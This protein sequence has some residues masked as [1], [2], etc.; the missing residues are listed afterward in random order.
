MP[1]ATAAPEPG[2]GIAPE[3]IGANARAPLVDPY[4]A[5]M[6][7]GNTPWPWRYALVPA[8]AAAMLTGILLLA[9]HWLLVDELARRSLL[10]AQHRA[11]TLAQQLDAQMRSAQR[12]LRLMAR[13][14]R[15]TGAPADVAA[16]LELLR[17][18]SVNF[19]WIG[20][21]TPD[22]IVRAATRGW[23]EGQSIASRPVFRQSLKGSFVGDAHPAVALADLMSRQGQAAEE[24]LDVGEPVFDAQGR[25]VAVLAAHLGVGWVDRL[26]RAERGEAEGHPVPG[27]S[28]HVLSGVAGRSVVAGAGAP[29]GVPSLLAQPALVRDLAGT[30]YF[31]ASADLGSAA[32]PALLP[33]R[34]LVLQERSAAL[35]PAW[36]V[37]RSMAVLGIGAALAIGLAGVW[38]SRRLLQPWGPM[39]R[40]VL[41]RAQRGGGDAR[42]LAEDVEAIVRDIEQRHAGHALSGPEALLLRLARDASD[43]RRVVDHLPICVALIDAGFRVEYLNPAYT[44]LLGWTTERVRGRVAAEFL[45][46]AV[47]RAEFVRQ[48]DLLDD[49]PGQFGARFFA[50][51]P[52]G[53]RVAVQWQFVPML[54]A[55]G[56]MAGAIALAHDIR[57][58]LAARARADALAGRLRALADAA[59]DTLLSTLDGEG[60]VL[61]WNR[62]AEHL[63]GLAAAAAL[64]RP[65]GDV[66][67][68]GTSIGA[69][70][71]EA[72]RSGRCALAWSCTLVGGRERRFEGSVYP[73]GLAPGTARFGLILHDLTEQHAVH[74]ALERSEA[75]MR[76]AMDAARIGTWEI[77]LCDPHRPVTWSAGYA[78]T[79]GMHLDEL[80]RTSEALYALVHPEDH[81][82]VRHAFVV[83]VRDA[84]ALRTEFRI[85]VEPGWRWHEI[86]GRAIRGADGQALRVGGIGMDTTERRLAEAELRAGRERL[87]RILHTM[88]EGLVTFD[89]EGRYTMVNRATERIVGEPAA[90]IIG[91]RYDD[92]SWRRVAPD[93]GEQAP[94]NHAFARLRRGEP[95]I[96]GE[97]VGV[98][99]AGRPPRITS[100]NAQPVFGAAGRFEGAV[101]TYVDIT[102]RW[103][104]ERALADSQARLSAVVG[105][106]SDAILS[107]D[108][109][110]RISL[111]NPAAERI[112]GQPAAD[113][114]GQ[115]LDRLLPVARRAG[116]RT[117]LHGFAASGVSRR[118]MGAGRVQGVHASGRTLELEASISQARVNGQVVLTAILRDVTDRVAQEQALDATRHE[119]AQLNRRLLEQEKE[120]TRHV[121]QALH[122]ELGQTLSALR[123]NWDALD[124][125]PEAVRGQH[126]DRLGAL[127][128]TANRQ[129]RHVLGELRPPLLDEMGL[130]AALDNELQQ[131]RPLL[132]G[133]QLQLTVPPRLHAHR[134]PPDVEY[135]AFMI[136]REALVN[137]LQHASASRVS[138]T[139][140]G[141]AG[142]LRLCV[143]DDGVGI[144]AEARAGRA[145]HLGLVG[146]RERAFAIGAQL[147]VDSSPGQGT[148][149]ELEW[150]LGDEQ[151]LP[152]R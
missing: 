2:P 1:I 128:V 100:L 18:Q 112:F 107:A 89:A 29:D 32:A 39:F 5:A 82:A 71:L 34:V 83:A 113:M 97:V 150:T 58:E 111:F 130:A 134:W 148:T 61:E 4:I 95:P 90:R 140:D 115:P 149:V 49:P 126:W 98:Q 141:D 103:H 135:A 78:D 86:H 9:A 123:L 72:R 143:R 80:P 31:A 11:A 8:L 144:A 92:V 42:R 137:A 119:L 75:H 84:G 109:E 56:H 48:F 19:V 21:V 62:G 114:L 54:G 24:L 17:R 25:L 106:A 20:Q 147:R 57:P 13:S 68:L 81:E 79:F 152:D 7:W 125:V 145:G 30:R 41:A 88:A 22:G 60:R 26:Q 59:V 142:E 40:V 94:D 99:P 12:E 45:F 43:L 91:R 77:D 6:K 146:M 16:E 50:L 67:G 120:T 74:Q 101:V 76:L 33:W 102:E 36:N 118:A 116:H 66:L 93:G 124:S 65:L 105:S 37:M 35:S 117:Q 122:D 96:L 44:R 28:L 127:V 139:L 10:R 46:D 38:T 108:L 138:L 3:G 63:S 129:I 52:S 133:P 121:A 14:Q 55:D 151:D 23:L 70:L 51:T 69:S 64:G 85:R 73:L 87:E 47:E 15:L 110:G 131:Q 53:E 27:L 136:G 132:A 104:A